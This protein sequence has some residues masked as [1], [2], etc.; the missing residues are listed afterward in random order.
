MYAHKNRMFQFSHVLQLAIN[1]AQSATL[2]IVIVV[3]S[4]CLDDAPADIGKG[5]KPAIVGNINLQRLTAD[6]NADDWLTLGRDYKQSYYSPLH[7]INKETVTRLGFAWQHEIEN[8]SGL[9][10]TPIVVD[11]ILFVSGPRGAVYAVNAKNGE[12]LW[13]FKPQIDTTQLSKVCCGQVNRGVAVWQSKVYVASIDG[14]LYALDAATGNQL[15]KVDTIT[16]RQRGYSITGAPYIANN[17]VVIGNSG[18]DMD[19]RGYVTAYTLDTGEQRWRFFLVPGDPAKGVEHPE[20]AMALKTWD[21]NSLWNV[22]LGGN[23][24]DGMA[25]D[26][27]LNLLYVGTG[28]ATPYSRKLRSPNGG[29]NLFISCILAINPDT[30]RLVWHY[31]TTPGD[32]WDYTATAKLVLSDMEIN[33]HQRK[34]IMQAPKNGFFYVLDRQTGELLS[35]EPYVPINWAKKVDMA[36]GKPVETGQGDYWKQPRLIMP[37]PLG[38]HNWQPMAF[39]P[40]TGLM[41]IPTQ[42]GAAILAVPKDKFIYRPAQRNY[43]TIIVMAVPGLTGFDGPFMAGL[44]KDGLPSMEIMS[45]GQ[46]DYK[47]KSGLIAWDPQQQKKVWEVDTSDNFT[48]ELAALRN[49]GGV[50]TTASDLIFQGR[51]SGKLFVYDAKSGQQLHSIDV[52]TSILAAPITYRVDGE[53]YVAVMAAMGQ[54]FPKEAL[55]SQDAAVGRIIAFK[56]GGGAVPKPRDKSAEEKAREAVSSELLQPPLPRRGTEEQYKTGEGIYRRICSGC[57]NTGVAPNLQL[58]TAQ[59]HSDFIAIVMGGKRAEKGMASF[60]HLLTMDEAEAL[61]NYLIDVAWQAYD[62][63]KKEKA[64]YH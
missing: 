40:N 38:G 56:L 8:I 18:G 4:G 2:L 17:V 50:M 9:E 35:A 63:K 32:S 51:G 26:P 21:P 1:I 13:H 61:H 5:S 55:A 52:G 57:H 22:G 30:G 29:D 27:T 10:A 3:L 25:Y 12:E 20:L 15:W 58:M 37:S 41:Y 11:G 16:D 14:Y 23:A 47:S 59:T 48:G 39:N 53:Q 6:K 19:A 49:G 42:R 54:Y 28:N 7:A 43:N 36:T 46:P 24:W 45:K 44:Q 34:V 64:A 31:Q 62:N 33:G 60:S